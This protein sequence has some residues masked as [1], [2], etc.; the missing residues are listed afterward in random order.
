MNS[1]EQ[2]IIYE[3]L[4]ILNPEFATFLE[5]K[6]TLVETPYSIVRKTQNGIEN[7]AFEFGVL[8]PDPKKAPWHPPLES[9]GHL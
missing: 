4:K 7:S 8:I 5:A 3:K 6:G 1:T 2:R 9:L